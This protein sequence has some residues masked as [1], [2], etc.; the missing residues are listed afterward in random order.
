MCV[1]MSGGPGIAPPPNGHLIRANKENPH[2]WGVSINIPNKC[3]KHN[4]FGPVG[5]CPECRNLSEIA[6]IR[7]FSTEELIDAVARLELLR[8]PLSSMVVHCRIATGGTITTEN[9]HPFYVSDTLDLFHNGI[10]SEEAIPTVSDPKRPDSYHLAR[11]IAPVLAQ[12]YAWLHSVPFTEWMNA[13]CTSG[14]PSK[15]LLHDAV[16]GP[17]LYNRNA[18]C[19][20]GEGRL[21]SNEGPLYDPYDYQTDEDFW[22]ENPEFT[23]ELDELSFETW[24]DEIRRQEAQ[25]ILANLRGR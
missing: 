11:L 13:L 17:V 4:D 1:I 6:H 20:G 2:G 22:K 14:Y 15:V 12:D 25:E 3:R 9:I 21:Y 16:Y 10:F 8:T 18:W 23:A 24:K 19:D 5:T 7:G